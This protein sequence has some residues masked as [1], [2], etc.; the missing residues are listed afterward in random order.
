MQQ[1]LDALG[2]DF[3]PTQWDPTQGPG[4]LPVGLHKVAVVSGGLK[5]TKANDGGFLELEL[6][7]IEGPMTGCRGPI[8]FNIHNK[9]KKTCDIASE[10]LSSL[11]HCVGHLTTLSTVAPLVG[12]PF[13]IEIIPQSDNPNYTDVAGF[14]DANG[15]PPK[16]GGTP[17]QQAAPP[18][19]APGQSQAPYG[20]QIVSQPAPQQ[21]PP[22]YG[23]PP[24]QQA[25]QGYGAPP[26][27]APS[28]YQP[29]PQEQQNAY[30]QPG[31]PP[32]QTQWQQPAPGPA[33]GQGMPPGMP[34][35]NNWENAT[36]AP[37][38]WA[39]PGQ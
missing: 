19:Q 25:P 14:F 4:Q 30:V 35:P 1:P 27:Q 8:R 11:C 32:A 39:P 29:S 15:Q 26:Q 21:A 2:M 17:V 37:A 34:G 10:K 16:R 31:Q 38:P 12:K 3:E 5:A 9:T 22:S 6:Q 23:P 33:P 24:G 18:Q 36:G 13:T 7:I 20:G 28:P